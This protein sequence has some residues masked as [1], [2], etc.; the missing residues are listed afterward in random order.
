[1]N[2]RV[3]EA[4]IRSG[5]LDR[6]GPNRA[7]L[8]AELDRAMHLG[9]QNSRAM[10][11]GQ[12]DLFGLSAAPNTRRGGLDRG[13]APG[14]RARDA[15]AVPERPSRSRPYEPDL[16]FLVSARLAD[17]GG[18]KPAAAADGERGWSAGQARD[19]RRP[20][21]RDPPPAESG[22][23]DPGR[24]QRPARGQPV[25]GDLSAASRHHRQG[26]DTDRRRHAAVRRFHRG[27][28]PA[29]EDR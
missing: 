27:V 15:R 21:A 25:R 9:E 19:R 17:V 1:M 23:V 5:S 20:G 11:V 26:R 28:A 3:F 10:S 4:L 13:A 7:T 8:T 22:D 14:R 6:I 16:K 12:V 18:P 24:P 29:G 2:R